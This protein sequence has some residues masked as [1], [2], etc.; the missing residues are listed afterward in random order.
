MDDNQTTE[1]T[2]QEICSHSER[3]FFDKL[4]SEISQYYPPLK[5]PNDVA[6]KK[7]NEGYVRVQENNGTRIYITASVTAAFFFLSFPL[8]L[9]WGYE[10]LCSLQISLL[11][12][13]DQRAYLDSHHGVV[14]GLV[15]FSSAAVVY[16]FFMHR[17]S[18][19]W[20]LPRSLRSGFRAIPP[21][22]NTGWRFGL[23]QVLMTYLALAVAIFLLHSYFTV[24]QPYTAIAARAW[25]FL[26]VIP[27]SVIPS[28]L[29]ILMLV[30][31]FPD[32]DQGEEAT[33]VALLTNILLLLKML[34]DVADPS[35]FSIQ[36]RVKA[37]ALI[38]RT[39]TLFPHLSAEKHPSSKVGL[40][41]QARMNLVADNFLALSAWVSFPKVDS[42][43]SLKNCLV[44]YANV[45]LSGA[46]DELPA[47]DVDE[48]FPFLLVSRKRSYVKRV[49]GLVW[50]LTLVTL[51]LL[52]YAA[53]T[54]VTNWSIPIPL[55]TPAAISYSAWVAVCLFAH[56]EEL[57]PEA[58]VALMDVL[59]L[60]SPR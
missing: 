15:L 51:P 54:I 34:K 1:K 44:N 5:V 48:T 4:F 46:F 19:R 26:P 6:L 42:V 16:A 13:L 28:I 10:A 12:Y 22:A 40:W 49:G 3:L 45:V 21:I 9:T 38:E 18:L 43:A 57:A 36:E 24:V 27:L 60:V 25:L 14:L 58:K 56:I 7:L 17:N 35:Q 29:L 32:E 2:E 59:R 31:F 55:Q 39:A 37:I 41:A 53:A 8:L 33:F 30:T 50:L 52:I 11:P 47:K 23:Y 20:I